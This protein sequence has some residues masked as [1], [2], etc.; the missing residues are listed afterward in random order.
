MRQNFKKTFADLDILTTKNPQGK[1]LGE[2]ASGNPKG[3]IFF[4]FC[5]KIVMA[6]RP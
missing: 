4:C 6:L 1:N 2:I 3:V 5:D